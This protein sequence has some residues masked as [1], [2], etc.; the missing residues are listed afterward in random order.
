[1]NLLKLKKYLLLISCLYLLISCNKHNK[2]TTVVSDTGNKNPTHHQPTH[3]KDTLK[4]KNSEESSN[5]HEYDQHRIDSIK[6][7]KTKP[8]IRKKGKGD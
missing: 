7:S 8:P 3:G 4:N 2:N 6:N 5:N 1:M